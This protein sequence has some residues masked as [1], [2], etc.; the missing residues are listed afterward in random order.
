MSQDEKNV[1]WIKEQWPN[2]SLNG[3]LPKFITSTGGMLK[4]SRTEEMYAITW[5]STIQQGFEL[6]TGGAALMNEGE[7]IMYFARKEQCLSLSRDLKRFKPKIID[8][9]IYRI[10]PNAEPLQVHPVDENFSEKMLKT[11]KQVNT[12]MRKTGDNPSPHTTKFTTKN[13]YD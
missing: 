8:Y 10:T 1:W 2:T 11:R 7:N 13:T 9:K 5:T 3:V 4:S 12:N 6:P